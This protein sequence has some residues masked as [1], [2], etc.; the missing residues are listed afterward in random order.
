MDSP[1][2]Y[3]P[4][5]CKTIDGVAISALL[6]TTHEPAPAIIMTHGFNCVKE[7]I[8]PDTAEAFYRAGNNVLL[9]D[10]RGVGASGGSPENLLD[11][12]Q[13]AEDLSDILTYV[14][15]LPSVDKRR[16]VQWGVSFG[17]AVV[18]CSAAIDRRVGAVVLVGPLFRYVQPHKADAAFAELIQDRASQLRGDEPRSVENFTETGDNMIGMSG[19]GGP[20][21]LEAYNIV[22]AAKEYGYEGFRDTVSLQTYYK[23]ALFR[24]L[25]YM[26]MIRAPFMMII[27]EL[28]D[29]SPPDEQRVALAKV[30]SRRVEYLARGKG[31]LNIIAG[32]GS[33]EI[34]KATVEFL[35]GIMNVE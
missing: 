17:A 33:E 16:I 31:H 29:I 34:V 5:E 19:A 1:L 15:S 18:V 2:H 7:M 27:P 12:L 4:V 23:L 6:W 8:L 13:M 10:P 28:D 20:G 35:R 25:E 3:Q 26:D 32:E 24:P 11:P 21:G 14:E 22:R 9:Y 30:K